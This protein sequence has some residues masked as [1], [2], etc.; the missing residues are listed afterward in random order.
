MTVITRRAEQVTLAT[1]LTLSCGQVLANRLMKSAL[2][3]GLA[4]ADGG[5]GD[6]I[7][8]LYQRWGQGG[9]GLVVTGNVMVDQHHLGEPG[10]V[11]VED[12]R[13]LDALQRWAKTVQDGDTRI[14]MQINHPGRQANPLA[15][16]TRPVAPSPVGIAMP[17]TPQPR[18]LADSEIRD[19]IARFAAT[20]R[21]AEE[22]G[23]DG[24]QVHAAHGYLVSQFLSPLANRRTDHW[25]GDDESRSRFL[26]EILRAVRESVRPGFAIGVKLNSADF[27]RGGFTEDQSR[28]VIRR[29]SVERVDLI[30]ISGGNYESP[31][32]LV[33][34]DEGI[35]GEPADSTARREAYFLRFAAEARALAADT[36][37]AVTGGFRTRAAMAS[38]LAEGSCDVVGL[39]RPAVLVPDVAHQLTSEAIE[40]VT[41]R[42]PQAGQSAPRTALG[43]SLR[44]LLDLQWH[45]DQLHRMGAGRD[46][47]LHRAVA[48]TL[49]SALRRNGLGALISP[50][51][52]GAAAERKRDR[53][54]RRE[55]V[56]GRYVFNPMV[57]SLD[58]LGLRSDYTALLATTGRRSGLRR[59]VPVS[60]RF[61]DTGA[62]L[63]SQ[64]GARSGWAH[65]IASDPRVQIKRGSRWLDGTAALRSDDDPASRAASFVS[66]RW[67][68]PL[69]VAGFQA[70]QTDPISVRITFDAPDG[71]S[72]SPEHA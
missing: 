18:E 71:D 43:K 25:G 34:A 48:V 17:G 36:P 61:D 67:L 14:W 49:L 11:I 62:W 19:I 3:E 50:R 26:I 32:A 22:A 47:D 60:A 55:I 66:A 24:V 2:S 1:P 56:I 7:E 57:R 37:I 13:H 68:R 23:F 41:S 30:E 31:A 46:P 16:R 21:V 69:V 20:A 70:L 6:R 72:P 28:E 8:R 9:F 35:G 52:L 64:H 59:E 10:N 53:K 27:Q 58:R 15:T 40:T 63:V 38:A 42:P 45:T 33:G 39:G 4:E 51:G 54:F 5:P 29:L 65:N 44:G 12:S